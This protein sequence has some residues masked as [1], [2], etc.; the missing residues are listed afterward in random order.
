[1][2]KVFAENNGKGQKGGTTPNVFNGGKPGPT[3]TPTPVTLAVARENVKKR[4]KA[5][6]LIN[7]VRNGQLKNNRMWQ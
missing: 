4:Q 1:M 6:A 2:F 7:R 5:Q 3:P